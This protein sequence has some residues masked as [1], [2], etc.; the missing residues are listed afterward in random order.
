[1]TVE[2]RAVLEELAKATSAPYR[3]VLQARALLLAA[4]GVGANEV[5]RWAGTTDDS[6]RAWRRTQQ[7][8]HGH[9]CRKTD[10]L[11]RARR[12]LLRSV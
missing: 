4:V 5:A 8:L 6:V 1:M 12:T 9:R 7:Q 3:K 11:N 10:P 2:Q